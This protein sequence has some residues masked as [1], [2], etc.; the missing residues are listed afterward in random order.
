VLTGRLKRGGTVLAKFQAPVEA[1]LARF[2]EQY[3][4]TLQSGFRVIDRVVAYMC[5]SHGKGIRP[6]LTLLCAS[7]NDGVPNEATIRAAVIVELLHEAT[8]VHD[9]V[10]DGSEERRGLPSLAAR[11]KNKIAVLFGDYMLAG[12]LTETLSARDL[13][14][15][16]ILS[17]TARRMA[18]GQLM[19][20]ARARRLDMNEADYVEMTGDKTAA[21]FSASCRL[22]ALSVNIP[23]EMVAALGI[24][25]EKLGIA[26][27]VRDDMLDL[28][29]GDRGFGKPVGRDMK[30]KK[31]TLPLLAAL[32]KVERREAR[33]IKARLRRGLKRGETKR[34]IEF[35]RR[36]G[37]DVYAE[38]FMR[39]QVKGAVEALEV[40]PES[41]IR[42]LLGEL[43]EFSVRRGR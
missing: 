2:R 1:D 8:L 19:E 35:V 28:F 18:K 43:A 26:F 31:L 40:L 29:G 4:R 30:D 42:D 16:D 32:S 11:F 37:G 39:S 10:V 12:V 33:R 7:L 3:H 41:P 20:A 17:E 14:W 22:G 21:L 34:I 23:D 25:G 36:H 13:R 27:Q 9:D 5:R 24:Y 15:L 6:T 38:E